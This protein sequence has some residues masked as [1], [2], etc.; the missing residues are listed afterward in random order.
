MSTAIKRKSASRGG[1][2]RNCATDLM[3]RSLLE[4]GWRMF[5]PRRW[6][7]TARPG[8]PATVE[9]PSVGV[10]R[11]LRCRAGERKVNGCREAGAKRT[12]SSCPPTR[13][14]SAHAQLSHR[15]QFFGR[16]WIWHDHGWFQLSP[17][18]LFLLR[19][20]IV[21]GRRLADPI[22]YWWLLAA[23]G[24]AWRSSARRE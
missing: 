16:D 7:I 14:H 1:S 8:Q 19:F 3:Q 15:V 4:D 2:L 24:S 17:A 23:D 5:H 10:W 22:R 9:A 21:A 6:R 20:A 13:A 18:R 12:T 11:W